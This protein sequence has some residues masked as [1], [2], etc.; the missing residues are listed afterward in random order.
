MKE[1]R[2]DTID[3]S[4]ESEI[5]IQPDGRIFAFGITRPV[6]ELLAAI[7]TSEA[8]TRGRS[9]LPGRPPGGPG[10]TEDL[11]EREETA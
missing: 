1:T 2:P 7:P 9:G 11:P 5:T 3:E 8:R 6:M 10:M 4:A